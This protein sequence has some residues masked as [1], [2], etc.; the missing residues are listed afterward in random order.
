MG[1][2]VAAAS[3]DADE[4]LA[5]G[6]DLLIEEEPVL[7]RPELP[8]DEAMDR[9]GVVLEEALWVVWVPEEWED[10]GVLAEE[11]EELVVDWAVA[12]LAS[13]RME[14][15]ESCMLNVCLLGCCFDWFVWM[16]GV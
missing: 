13:A 15:V 10:V 7:L 1:I 6:D 3:P 4:V 12:M 16:S 11:R 5:D 14:M 9:C 2:A 8:E